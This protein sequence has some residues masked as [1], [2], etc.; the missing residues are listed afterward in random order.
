MLQ[1]FRRLNIAWI[2][3][4]AG[5]FFVIM[6][7]SLVPEGT[8]GAPLLCFDKTCFYLRDWT[9]VLIG[10]SVMILALSVLIRRRMNRIRPVRR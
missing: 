7:T 2:I 3:L 6:G 4:L 5:F 10:I 1:L 8:S 9:N